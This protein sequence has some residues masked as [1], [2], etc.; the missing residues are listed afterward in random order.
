MFT[1]SIYLIVVL[2]IYSTYQAPEITNFSFLESILLFIIL[3]VSFS[4]YTYKRFKKIN[5]SITSNDT[6]YIGR[7]IDATLSH[8]SILAIVLFTIDIYVLNLPSFFYNL[9]PFIIFP[10]LLSILFISIFISYLTIIWYFAYPSYQKIT[11]SDFSRKSYIN[12]NIRFSV[13]MLLPWLLLSGTADIIQTLPFDAPK[14][15]LSTTYGQLSYFLFFLLIIAIFGPAIIQRFWQC[16]SLENNPQRKRIEYLCKQA[17][18]GYSDILSW[19]I[20][21]GRMITAGVM[22]LVRK[23]RYILVTNALLRFLEPDEIDAVIAHEIGHVKKYH[24]SFYLLFFS[25]YILFSYAVF[26][27]IILLIIYL[28]PSFKYL[29]RSV[30][31]MEGITSSII[32]SFL[33]F[34]FIVYFR[35]I[36]GFFMRNF[37][38]QADTYVY[39]LFNSAM[40]LISTLKKIAATSGQSPDKPNW[41]HFSINERIDY[42]NKC[43][44]D[45]TWIE[46][47][48][49][50]VRK[51][52]VIFCLG[53]LCVGIIGYILNFG[54]V[55][56]S[57]SSNFI[58]SILYR[59]IEKN[60]NDS[61]L[62][63]AL[64]DIYYQKN[65]YSK[66]I[67]AYE[68]S[69][70]ISI[71][72]PHALNNLAWL[73][74]IC[75][76]I[77]YRDPKRALDLSLK[78]VRLKM[79]PHILDTLAESYYVNGMFRDAVGTELKAME[80]AKEDR[81]H[82]E[83]QLMKYKEALLKN[84]DEP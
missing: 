68:T 23:F 74:A 63:N 37:E 27:L 49:K 39:K 59:E 9:F 71:E 65:N 38:R 41:H 80:L 77:K 45:R 43:E 79:E 19:P 44:K 5:D 4:Y 8:Q 12:S 62:Y 3:S 11:C 50:K 25:G 66:T 18:I 16:K 13:P 57:L 67:H 34:N 33:I 36:F 22:G 73:Y 69:L 48:D 70:T 28:V 20:L 40:P 76:E 75:E 2:L 52:I 58:E 60:P 42:L 7:Q 72:N 54:Q 6:I 56:K 32:T 84:K 24:L 35:Y 31:S 30:M 64:G 29:T 82:Y 10:T 26:N 81:S 55:G 15:F 83:N 14:I 47:H 1:N 21:S 51:S 61:S 53:L 78:A 46:R 17:D